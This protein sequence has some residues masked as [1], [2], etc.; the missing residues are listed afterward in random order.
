MEE[1]YEDMS[2][3][4]RA[5]Q[6]VMEG[7]ERSFKMELDLV[8]KNVDRLKSNLKGKSGYVHPMRY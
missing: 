4:L 5:N 1:D 2:R 7:K 6:L 3:N 8:N